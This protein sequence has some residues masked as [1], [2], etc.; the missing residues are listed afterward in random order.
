MKYKKLIQTS[1]ILPNFVSWVVIN[2]LLFA[3]FSPS[4]GAIS[5]LLEFF[6]FTEK[7]PNIMAEKDTFRLVILFSHIWK[8][9]GMG[10]IVYLAAIAGVDKE[11]YEAAAIDGAG[12]LR[13]M[14]HITLSSIRSTIIIL[15][16]FRV[17]HVM[18][19]GFDQIFAISNPLVISVADIIDTYVYTIGLEQR[20][21]TQATAAGLFQSLIGLVLVLITNTIANRYDPDSSIISFAKRK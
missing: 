21:F 4:S 19:A 18:Q 14:W 10:T 7:I 20:N 3:I 5:G 6:G 11:L 2:G 15:L 1:V 16:I 13:Q 9:A 12:R 8:N 17:G